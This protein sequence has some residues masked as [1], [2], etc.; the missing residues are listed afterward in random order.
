MNLYGDLGWLPRAPE[1]FTAVCRTLPDL[2]PEDLPLRLK[3]LASHALDLNQLG[4]LSRT[5]DKLGDVPSFLPLRLGILS[6]ATTDFLVPA[7]VATG[8]RHGL[9]ITPVVADYGQIVQTALDPK[10]ALNRE[11][12]DAVLMA[13][14]Y[15]GLALEAPP[16]DVAAAKASV[17]QALALVDQMRGSLRQNSGAT[18]ICQ[19]LAPPAEA[20]LG[21]F[22]AMLA[23]SS[24]S[25]IGAFNCGLIERLAASTDRLFDVAALAELVGLG[26]W[27]DPVLWNMAKQPFSHDFIALYADHLCRV[28]AVMKGKT[29]KVLVLDL[30]NTVWGGII[31]DDGMDGIRIAQGDAVGEAHLAVQATAL[32]L[33]QR[34]ILLAVSSKN[35]DETAREVFRSHPEMLLREEHIA[36]FQANWNDKATN[37]KAIAETLSLGIDSF[38]FLDDNPVERGLVRRLLPQVAVPEL[39]EDPGYYARTLLAA[40]YF[41]AV[42]FSEEDRKRAGFYSANAQRAALAQQ[43][44]GVE[45][46]LKSL[47]MTIFFQNFDETGRARIAQLINKSN[48]FNLTT[49]RYTEQDV[50]AVQNDPSAF[51]LQIRLTDSFGDNGMISVVICRQSGD[52]WEIDSWLMSCRVLARRV[53]QG[54]LEELIDEARRRGVKKLVGVYRPTDRNSMVKDHY[55]GLGFVFEGEGQDG[56]TRWGLVLE[57]AKVPDLFAGERVRQYLLDQEKV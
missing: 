6:N 44:G 49:R 7:I 39:P 8:L 46:Y 31:G 32:A 3:F 55:A 4:R 15:R 2:S 52:A 18:V 43:I 9:R 45:D 11:P 37:I 17:E 23:G 14:D 20:L 21:G 30:D 24:R 35:N 51:T 34:G 54:V 26:N 25:Q 41:E 57:G 33:R 56:E 38:V 1:D 5:L 42:G 16:G 29:R 27:H 36:V 40:G 22:D 53:E 19:T 50:A 13:V 47:G 28:L 48:Q 10:S 12:L